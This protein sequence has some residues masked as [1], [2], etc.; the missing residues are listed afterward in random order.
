MF[1]II[2]EETGEVIARVSREWLDGLRMWFQAEF[3]T[4]PAD[5]G[6]APREYAPVE[7]MSAADHY[8]PPPKPKSGL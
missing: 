1:A 3:K 5:W 4:H 7:R 8:G 6:V 2:N